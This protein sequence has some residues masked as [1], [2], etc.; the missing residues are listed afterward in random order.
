[1][2]AYQIENINLKLGN[3]IEHNWKVKFR[4]DDNSIAAEEVYMA[5]ND[6]TVNV[7]LWK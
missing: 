6:E 7:T 4:E 5:D 1:M 2:F 3:G